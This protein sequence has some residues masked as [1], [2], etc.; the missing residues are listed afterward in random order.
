[1]QKRKADKIQLLR[2]LQRSPTSDAQLAFITQLERDAQSRTSR[3]ART[4]SSRTVVEGAS[5]SADNGIMELTFNPFH[6]EKFEK[7]RGKQK[8]KYHSRIKQL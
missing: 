4:K 1:M 3:S 8:K 6:L 5:Q 2:E 7:I